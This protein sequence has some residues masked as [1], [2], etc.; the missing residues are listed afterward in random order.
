MPEEYLEDILLDTY[1]RDSY[2]QYNS[3][4]S[5]KYVPTYSIFFNRGYSIDTMPFCLTVR[6]DTTYVSLASVFKKNT[7]DPPYP[8]EVYGSGTDQMSYYRDPY[9]VFTRLF[10]PI[11]SRDLWLDHVRENCR[12]VEGLTAE[13][14]D[15]RNALVSWRGA[16]T[17][18]LYEVAY[19]PADED[20]EDY[21]VDTTG[22]PQYTLSL[23]D[24]GM[25]Y[26][27]RVRGLC[28]YEDTI[29]VWSGWSDTIHYQRPSFRLAL[30]SNNDDWG[31]VAG[32]GLYEPY[33]EVVFEP[34]AESGY[35]FERWDD[36]DSTTPRSITIESDTAFMA[37][38]A[39]DSEEGVSVAAEPQIEVRPNP[40][41]GSVTISG[42][43]VL[44]RVEL[45]DAIGVRRKDM[46]PMT[47]QV[48]M[49]LADCPS[50][51]YVVTVHTV[52]G[53][54]SRRLAV[55]R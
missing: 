4:D 1:L 12:G 53:T 20:P 23:L 41:A 24:Y 48:T 36:G 39:R 13:N 27:V 47:Q 55:A 5:N 44:L 9:P 25:D 29:Q 7:L 52:H 54:A 6:T 51:L 33:I 17:H 31:S 15:G 34:Q 43:E 14:V 10:F 21:A 35:H 16:A 2:I 46:T 49:D 42:E 8:A 45:R 40:A 37:L 18:C 26:A 3:P 22:L 11:V 30:T 32:S 38:F 19:G 28:C 50:G